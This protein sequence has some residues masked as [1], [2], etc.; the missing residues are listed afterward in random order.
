MQWQSQHSGRKSLQ[1][2]GRVPIGQFVNLFVRETGDAPAVVVSGVMRCNSSNV[3]VSC[4][5]RIGKHRR[6]VVQ[7]VFEQAHR[8]GYVISMLTFTIR[9]KAGDDLKELLESM[10]EAYKN[11]VSSNTY[12]KLKRK[13]GAEFLRITEVTHGANGWH[14]HFHVAI[15]ARPGLNW[16]VEAER[17]QN[18]WCEAV[19]RVGLAAPEPAR[20]FHILRE[21]MEADKAWY[22]QKSS[23]TMATS[24]ISA[25]VANGRWKAGRGQNV[26][27]WQLLALAI[28]G[29]TKALSLWREY[30]KAVKRK[31]FFNPSRGFAMTFGFAWKDENQDDT[32]LLQAS[33]F[34]EF[35]PVAQSDNR[36]QTPDE[37]CVK[38]GGVEWVGALDKRTWQAILRH[39][40]LP[41]FVEAV[42]LGR[43]Q[44][45]TFL[46]E[47]R[48]DGAIRSPFSMIETL[49]LE[50]FD[51]QGA[52]FSEHHQAT[53]AAHRSLRVIAA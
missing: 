10:T 28:R 38:S 12:V 44:A 30:E 11:V 8:S 45:N 35:L 14:P 31:Q 17:L 34:D 21:A 25:E 51:P 26:S 37:P 6:D 15:V 42:K 46:H 23:G 20:A 13:Y 41:E 3:C 29:D 39:G 19:E 36:Q 9:H 24:A 22:L 4:S 18:I 5:S 40:L 7:A 47:H 53:T 2:C 27:V 43:K 49:E 50:G 48:I 16:D 33:S 52:H 32:D 1:L